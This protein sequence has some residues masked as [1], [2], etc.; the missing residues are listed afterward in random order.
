MYS[1]PPQFISGLEENNL[2]NAVLYAFLFNSTIVPEF[3]PKPYLSMSRW[4]GC[5]QHLIA[6][7]YIFKIFTIILDTFEFSCYKVN[8]LFGKVNIIRTK[9]SLTILFIFWVDF[10]SLLY[11]ADC[12]TLHRSELMKNSNCK[13]ILWTSFMTTILIGLS[14]NLLS[15]FEIIMPANNYLVL[16]WAYTNLSVLHA[17]VYVIFMSKVPG[18][19]IILSLQMKKLKQKKA[20][21]FFFFL[22]N[23]LVKINPS[24]TAS[25]SLLI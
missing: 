12:H 17:L 15:P 6:E 11:F 24:D 21:V 10:F 25:S 3:Q 5:F 22:T 20:S 9:K 7:I 19:I 18:T 13:Q 4:A 1:Q 14:L 16:I 8:I 23:S 2:P